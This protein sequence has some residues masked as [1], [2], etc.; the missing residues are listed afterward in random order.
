M[1]DKL[2]DCILKY[3]KEHRDIV[4]K[5]CAHYIHIF[6]VLFIYLVFVMYITF[7]RR[8]QKLG[9]LEMN[10]ISSKYTTACL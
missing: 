6:C 2:L 7:H 3:L 4:I 8:F 10:D 9:F 5:S 1:Y